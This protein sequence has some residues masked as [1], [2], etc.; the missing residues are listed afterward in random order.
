[1][2]KKYIFIVVLICCFLAMFNHNLFAGSVV[3]SK[4]DF[5]INN[6]G[7][8][9]PNNQITPFAKN[10]RLYYSSGGAYAGQVTEVCVFCHTPHNA[11][12]NSF[13]QIQLAGG[14]VN[15]ALWNR[16]LPYAAGS[17]NTNYKLYTSVTMTNPA[18]PTGTSLMCLSCHDGVT[19][20]GVQDISNPQNTQS[21]LEVGAGEYM[22][23]RSGL[24]SGADKIGTVYNGGIFMP[25]GPNIGNLSFPYDGSSPIDLSNDHP[26]S[27]PWSDSYPNIRPR[28]QI[29]ARLKLY[30]ST[31]KME[32]TTCHNVHDET[33]YPP[34]LVMSNDSS[35]MC[36]S[37]HIK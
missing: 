11:S 6:D 34:F 16:V 20:I 1:M 36:L 4:H 31:N 32:C 5:S 3:N 35:A 33:T 30:G 28:A 22:S 24:G 15:Q 8:N 14:P 9:A 37:C 12:A 13:Y 18:A 27:F 7:S 2:N 19:G 17:N 10:F 26:V 25:W 29:D 21:L 23:L